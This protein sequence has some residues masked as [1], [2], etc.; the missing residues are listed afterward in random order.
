MC[1]ITAVILSNENVKQATETNFENLRSKCIEA[2]SKIRHRGPDWSGNKSHLDENGGCILAHER[3]EIIDPYGGSQPLYHNF[4]D[5]DNILLTVNGEIYNHN[6]LREKYSD[7]NYLT[8]SDCEVII[9]LYLEFK[10]KY[11]EITNLDDNND[12]FNEIMMRFITQIDG[13]FSFVLYDTETNWTLVVRD[14]IGITSLYYG[15][16]NYNNVWF[17]SEAKALEHCRIVEHFPNG[18]LSFSELWCDSDN[19]YCRFY[20]YLSQ[21][22]QHFNPDYKI[23]FGNLHLLD[24]TKKNIRKIFI[25]SV[26]KRLMSDVQYGTLLSGGLDSSLVASIASKFKKDMM[27][28]SIGLEGSPDLEKAQ[29]VADFIGTKHFGFK[30][31]I[32]EGLDS[33]KDIIK[34]VETYD[35]TTVRASTPMYLLARRIKALGV[36]MV[37]SGEGSD[38]LL[39][40][41]LYFLNAPNNESLHYECVDRVKALSY[42]DCMR[43]NKSLMAWGVEGRVPF[44]DKEVVDYFL[45]INPTFKDGS[46]VGK[47]IEKW[48]LREA[49][50][51]KDDITGKPV[52]LPDDLLWRQKEQ[53]SDGVGYG[54]IDSI[55]EMTNNMYS[56]DEFESKAKLYSVNPPKTKE[57]LYYREE[58]EK[59]FPNRS[60]ICKQWIPKM[61][62]KGVSYDPSGR[63]QESHNNAYEK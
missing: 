38:E 16:D 35:I 24:E 50:D 27:S 13:Q 59:I 18:H 40:G 21:E 61:D 25:N 2:S 29:E 5:N 43:A 30:F 37:L 28:F 57:A 54:W 15:Y 32:Q 17:S 1:G 55:V 7:Y 14:P 44:L 22:I 11:L 62:W 3:L 26:K 36:K 58:F 47:K 20:N 12:K 53:F 31:T 48:I 4:N 52:Y 42:F 63:A 56:D 51:V 6:E 8:S 33:I 46:V 39:G 45:S 9:P 49:F 41:Y 60:N 34:Y 23:N 10:T 19:N